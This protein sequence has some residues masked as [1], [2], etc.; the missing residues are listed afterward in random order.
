MNSLYF[1]SFDGPKAT[2]KTTVLEAVATALRS[3]ARYPVVQLCEKELD[4]YRANTL[5]L[6]QELA[7]KPTE[8]LEHRVC[9]HLAAGRAWI[10]DNVL[11]QIDASSIVLIDRWYPSDAAFRRIIPFGQILAMNLDYRVRVPDLH[12][13]VVTNPGI[14]WARAAARTR[15]LSSVVIQ[16]FEEHVAC[17]D[18]FN[19]AVATNQWF[20]CRNETSIDDATML[21]KSAIYDQWNV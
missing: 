15:G 4:P 12:I 2:G 3:D 10:T 17:T 16:S 6:I 21:V 13:G 1:V 18:A 5:A 19:R 8:A 14:S 9:E 20:S 11:Q 7:A